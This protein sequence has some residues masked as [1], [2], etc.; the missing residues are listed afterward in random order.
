M[1]Y[2]KSSQIRAKESGSGYIMK[3]M[4]RETERGLKYYEF[5]DKGGY[6][7]SIQESSFAGVLEEVD[8]DDNDP[9]LLIGLN[10]PSIKTCVTGHGWTEIEPPVIKDETTGE[11]Y[12]S[13]INGRMELSQTQVKEILPIL[14]KFAKDGCL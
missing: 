13:F 8:Y 6:L 10:N 12:Y 5:K 1:Q 11:R 9:R 4:Q 2:Y 7:C 14:E 3:L